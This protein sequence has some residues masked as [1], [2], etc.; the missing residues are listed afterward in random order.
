ME[1]ERW[2]EPAYLSFPIVYLFHS[3]FI[4]TMGLTARPVW[5]RPLLPNPVYGLYALALGR[6]FKAFNSQVISMIQYCICPDHLC[7]FLSL[8]A[9]SD[10]FFSSLLIPDSFSLAAV[11]VKLNKTGL[12][13]VSIPA[14]LQK[15]WTCC[16]MMV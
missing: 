6:T 13:Y 2:K 14:C 8:P 4:F 10:S 5:L 12:L 15:R 16:I 1:K 7:C 3:K 9:A 11:S